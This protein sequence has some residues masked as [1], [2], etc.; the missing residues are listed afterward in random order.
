MRFRKSNRRTTKQRAE[1]RRREQRELLDNADESSPGREREV[2]ATK[3][4]YLSLE[5]AKASIRFHERHGRGP[6]RAYKCPIC[7]QWHHTKKW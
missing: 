5:E 2:C 7:H 1:R 3:K 4:A 6:L